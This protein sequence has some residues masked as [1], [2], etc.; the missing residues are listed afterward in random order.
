MCLRGSVE[1][2]AV[3]ASANEI[4]DYLIGTAGAREVPSASGPR[5]IPVI[6]THYSHT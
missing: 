2:Q 3:A 5:D 4:V 1:G 6:H